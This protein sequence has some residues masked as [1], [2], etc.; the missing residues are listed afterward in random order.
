MRTVKVGP[1]ARNFDQIKVGDTVTA[2]YLESVAVVVA[3]TGEKPA[4]SEAQTVEVA[5]KGEKPR[6][7]VVN[8][9]DVTAVVEK[10][11]YKKRMIS[12][13]GPEGNVRDFVVDKSV[14]KFKNI[15]IGDNVFVRLTEAVAITVE[16]PAQ[17]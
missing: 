13:K 2:Q 10:I 3:K 8:T 6:V 7:V 15:K 9:I 16:K 4:V 17:K 1:E 12:L 14:K 5:A 11:D